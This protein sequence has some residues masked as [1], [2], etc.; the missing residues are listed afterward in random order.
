MHNLCPQQDRLRKDIVY[1]NEGLQ[2]EI[3]INL[4]IIAFLDVTKKNYKKN[5]TFMRKSFSNQVHDKLSYNL[6]KGSKTQRKRN[7][8]WF[9]PPFDLKLL[10]TLEEHSLT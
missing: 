2:I 4:N 3:D 8:L 1:E 10:E 9:N 7:F 6:V 5:G